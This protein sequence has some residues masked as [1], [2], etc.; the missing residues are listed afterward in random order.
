MLGLPARPEAGGAEHA[1]GW[2]AG[3]VSGASQA[4]WVRVLSRMGDGCCGC[5]C[6]LGC[7]CHL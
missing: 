4:L 2:G 1:G 5:E 7:R 6:R 3:A